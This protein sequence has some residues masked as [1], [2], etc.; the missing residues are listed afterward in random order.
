[1]FAGIVVGVFRFTHR[2]VGN[3]ELGEDRSLGA[4]VVALVFALF[5][6]VL[7]PVIG[8]LAALA[9]AAPVR[10]SAATAGSGIARA[11]R[12]LALTHLGLV[13]VVAV[14]F[15]TFASLS[16]TEDYF[17]RRDVV[18][19]EE[20]DREREERDREQRQASDRERRSVHNE[21]E[22]RREEIEE[23]CPE[24][25]SEFQRK[26][27]GG[28]EAVRQAALDVRAR[29]SFRSWARFWTDAGVDDLL[30]VCEIIRSAP[31]E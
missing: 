27:T 13:A 28:Q 16:A 4:G 6:F 19:A 18:T 22:D 21:R 17:D 20:R 7:L 1:M 30:E 11:A 24:S 31:N 10:R 3:P 29:G 2:E 14:V 9:V 25:A 15:T 12:V 26:I 23:R 8:A 5:A